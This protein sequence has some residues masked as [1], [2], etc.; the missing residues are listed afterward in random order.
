MRCL[1]VFIAP[2][3]ITDANELQVWQVWQDFKLREMVCPKHT[4]TIRRRKRTTTTTTTFSMKIS[5]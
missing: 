3:A 5:I 2:R 1:W 4:V